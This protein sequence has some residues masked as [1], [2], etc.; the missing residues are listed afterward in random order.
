MV[1]RFRCGGPTH[2]TGMPPRVAPALS[3]GGLACG[4]E[5]QPAAG[6]EKNSKNGDYF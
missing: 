5:P 1:G 6:V 3:A 2:Y 4:V